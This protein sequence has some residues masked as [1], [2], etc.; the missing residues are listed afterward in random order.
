MRYVGRERRRDPRPGSHRAIGGTGT[1]RRAE[2]SITIER[3]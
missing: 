1:F 2:S 3:A